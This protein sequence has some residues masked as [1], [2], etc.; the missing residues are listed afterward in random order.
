[1]NRRGFTL[2]EVIIAMT[3]LV[4]IVLAM[5][6]AAGQ[7][8]RLTSQSEAQT[9]ASQLAQE[10]LQMIQMDPNY[11][12]LETTYEGTESAVAGATGFS[13]KTDIT[14]V[15]GGTATTDFKRITV[16]VTGPGLTGPVVRTT[17]VAA[18]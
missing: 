10:R 7:F 14:R 8:V 9:V 17:T 5:S 15:G 1:M 4:V 18:P 3:I 12:G 6:S 13:R 16:T 11:A 2:I